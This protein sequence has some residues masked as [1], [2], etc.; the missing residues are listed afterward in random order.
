LDAEPGAVIGLGLREAQGRDDLCAAARGGRIE[1]LIDWRPVKA[2]DLLYSPGGTIHALGAGLTLIEIQQ[3]LDLTY[4]LY[5]YGRERAL[6][7][8]TGPAVATLTPSDW[9]FRPQAGT[10]GVEILLDVPAF[11]IERWQHRTG[12]LEQPALIIPLAGEGRIDGQPLPP[13]SV[14]SAPPGSVV[15]LGAQ[16]FILLAFPKENGA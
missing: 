2:G 15:A 16:D 5:D 1:D 7:L 13:S 8:E 10:P 12:A 14:W 6:Q 9:R 11:R 3:N 4:R